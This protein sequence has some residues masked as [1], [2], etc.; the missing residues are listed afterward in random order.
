MSEP[1]SSENGTKEKSNKSSYVI[2]GIVITTIV[3]IV[4]IVVILWVVLSSSNGNN[5][6]GSCSTTSDCGNGQSC[7]TDKIS[8]QK[9]C[10]VN[11][12]QVCYTEY[13]CVP[14][15]K[16]NKTNTNDDTG[17]CGN[18]VINRPTMNTRNRKIPTKQ[19]VIKKPK[20]VIQTKQKTIKPKNNQY[21]DPK[22]EK[23][24]N[25]RFE[26]SKSEATKEYEDDEDEYEDEY[27]DC[28]SISDVEY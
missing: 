22:P 21:P 25:K 3:L 2:G 6:G 14:G 27:D 26:L 28:T 1:I 19:K 11:S 24:N 15:L 8:S 23:Q 13:D 10:K 12:G 4:V 5:I 18:T 16:C 9:F 7:I 17:I 20:K